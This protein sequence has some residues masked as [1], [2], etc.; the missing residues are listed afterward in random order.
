MNNAELIVAMLGRAGVRWAFGVPSGPVLPLIEAMRGSQ[1]EY[2]L[3]GSE[4]AAGYMAAMT[5]QLTGVPGVCVSTLG[6]G[7]TNLATGVGGAWLDR[8]PVVAITCNVPTPWLRRRIQMRIDHHALFGPIT[9]ASFPLRQ[10]LVADPL[11]KALAIALDEPPGPVH[12]DLPEDVAVSEAAEPPVSFQPRTV[13]PDCSGEVAAQLSEALARSRRPIVITGLTF[14]RSRL[15]KVLLR[16]I[17]RQRL[18]FITTA[19]AKGFLPESHPNWAGVIGRARR[20]NVQRF[21]E[22]ADL[23][24]A[25]GYDPIEINYEEWTGGTPIFHLSSEAAE[26]GDGLR[27]AFNTPLDLDRAIARLPELPAAA[28]D[29]VEEEWVAHRLAFER[30]LRPSL[31]P[32]PPLPSPPAPLPTVGRGGQSLERGARE[33]AGLTLHG[34]LDVLHA[35]LPPDGILTYDVGAHH[36]QV[37]SQWRTDEPWNCLSTNGW[38]SMG[39]AMPAAYAA[40]LVHPDRPVVAVLGDGCFHMTAGELNVARRLRLAVPHIVLNDGW[41]SL[42]KIKQDRHDYGYSGVFLGEPPES[43]P[44]YFGV[45]CRPARDAETLDAAIRWGLALDGPSVIE[46]FIDAGPLSETV[47]D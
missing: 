4:T 6:P 18:P 33:G 36:H 41:L 23:I 42:I 19:H 20:T 11:A 27:L 46:A 24:I 29:W 14:T 26:P 40:K 7:A 9:K 35:L 45:P 5:G 2:V 15:A 25:V 16:F 37:A 43:P 17:E 32:S 28:N 34:V 31:T 22:Q 39:I 38:S 44:H 21:V 47:Y 1:V 13:L 30:A 3:T 12:L 10:G 8:A